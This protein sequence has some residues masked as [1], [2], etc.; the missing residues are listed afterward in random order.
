M[1]GLLPGE[2]ESPQKHTKSRLRQASV[3]LKTDRARTA[4]R[5]ATREGAQCAKH[6]CGKPGATTAPSAEARRPAAAGPTE[7]P[8]KRVGAQRS[9]RSRATPPPCCA[10]QTAH[11]LLSP[12]LGNSLS[13]PQAQHPGRADTEPSRR[14]LRPGDCVRDPAF[15]AD[16]A[17]RTAPTSSC[18]TQTDQAPGGHYPRSQLCV[19]GTKDHGTRKPADQGLCRGSPDG[20][21]RPWG[22]LAER[23]DNE[24]AQL[25]SLAEPSPFPGPPSSRLPTRSPKGTHARAGP[26]RSGGHPPERGALSPTKRSLSPRC[27]EAQTAWGDQNRHEC[28]SS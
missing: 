1:P 20:G 27:A 28:H 13:L 6:S 15:R 9:P 17:Q 3:T 26:S 25:F 2:Q 18:P 11:V 10:H 8:A 12:P 21:G 7:V 4:V 5:E 16:T 24:V 19:L 14:P 23:E 22:R